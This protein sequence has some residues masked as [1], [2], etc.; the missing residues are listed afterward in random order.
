MTTIM[1]RE[2]K[3]ARAFMEADSMEASLPT[4]YRKTAT[5]LARQIDVDVT[6]ATP[7]GEMM[8]HP[9][10][11]IA[12]DNPPTHLWPIRREVF[13]ATYIEVEK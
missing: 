4:E 12:S 8:A 3:D 7:E 9:G 2:P 11:Y 6:I 1:G 5:V 10:D 13:E